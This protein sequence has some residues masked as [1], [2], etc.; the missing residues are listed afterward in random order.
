[1]GKNRNVEEEIIIAARKIFHEKGYKEA[2]MRDIASEANI[3]LA[4]LHYYYR[5]K[6]NLFFI[7]FDEAIRVLYEKIVKILTTGSIDIF[8]KIRQIVSEYVRFFYTNPTIPQFV[9]GEAIRNPEVIGKRMKNLINPVFTYEMFKDQL[10]KEIE[11]GNIR[12]ISPL[13]LIMNI[14]SLCIFPSITKPIIKEVLDEK[15]PFI[16]FSLETLENNIADFIINSIKM[17]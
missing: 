5:S 11:R 14:L 6:E 2:T 12:P 9:T 16:D 17:R 3:N 10:N 15:E 8:L 4:M 13:S 7:V 1:M